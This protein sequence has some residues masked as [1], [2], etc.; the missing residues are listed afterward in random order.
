MSNRFAAFL[1]GE[2]GVSVLKLFYKEKEALR[3]AVLEEADFHGQNSEM[4]RM[5]DDF[6][7]T[8][9]IYWKELKEQEGLAAFASMSID[10]GIL[11]SWGHKIESPLL[12]LTK[13]G[14][15]NG[16]PS[17]LPYCKGKHPHFWCIQDAAPCGGTLHLIDENLDTGP[18]AWQKEVQTDWTD[19][20]SSLYEKSW[21]AVHDLFVENWEAILALKIP[22]CQSGG[23]GKYH[24]AYE[25]GEFTRINLEQKYTARELLNLI[26]GRTFY[27]HPAAYFSD[28]NGTYEVRI[29]ITKKNDD[30]PNLT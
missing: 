3:L 24:F 6:P 23:A 5:L 14:Y 26:R 10:L 8:K 15:L 2:I 27:P 4:L 13:Y 7:E 25:L 20:G 28:E 22:S 19:T 18:I 29:T 30:T 9:I 17:F 11:V 21:K 1:A 12:H 16:H